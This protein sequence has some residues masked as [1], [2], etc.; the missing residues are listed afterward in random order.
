MKIFIHCDGQAIDRGTLT[1]FVR[2][3]LRGPWYTG[4]RSQGELVACQI[5]RLMDASGRHVEYH[6]LVEVRPA[7]V[8][9]ELIERLHGRRLQGRAVQLRKWFER[10][11]RGSDRR[12]LSGLAAF[13][14]ARE[15]RQGRERRR[16]VR[17]QYLDQL[18]SLVR[19]DTARARR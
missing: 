12:R 15:N 17:V 7:R 16:L 8:G 9:W 6:G 11:G 14:T 1:D 19:L 13:P 2:R 10:A 4:F 3:G 5:L 18:P